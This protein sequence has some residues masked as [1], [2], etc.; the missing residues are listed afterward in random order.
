MILRDLA[1]VR[2]AV[3]D[4]SQAVSAPVGP[5]PDTPASPGCNR[6]V[7]RAQPKT[8]TAHSEIKPTLNIRRTRRGG[9]KIIRLP[10]P[11]RGAEDR[12]SEPGPYRVVSVCRSQGSRR[13]PR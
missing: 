2:A 13:C 10:G 9:D 4:A 1:G 8:V 3:A 12:R 6:A 7:S 5:G 11:K